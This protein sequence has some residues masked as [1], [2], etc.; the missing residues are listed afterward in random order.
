MSNFLR[1][2]RPTSRLSD[3]VAGVGPGLGIA[4]VIALAAY[5]LEDIERALFGKAWIE[6]LVLAIVLGAGVR[7]AGL[8]AGHAHRGIEIAAKPV[9]E[10]A[11]VLLGASLDVREILASGPILI[12]AIA[13]IVALAIGAGVAIGRAL[14]LPAKMALLVACGNAICGNSAIA[15]VAPVIDAEPDDVAA[16]IGFTAVLGVVVV[17][18]MPMLTGAF[19]L[20]GAAAGAF[21]GLTAYAVPQVLAAAAPLGPAAVQ[22][23]AL[24]KLTRVLMLGPVCAL[25]ALAGR[26]LGWE[27]AGRAR[28]SLHHLVPWFILGFLALAMSRSLGWLPDRLIA[29]AAALTT[30]LTVVAMAGLGLGVDVRHIRAAGPRVTAAVVLSLL[31]LG[32]LSMAALAI[33]GLA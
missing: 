3:A 33:A 12:A 18:A 5:T 15:A 10:V 7:S 2:V 19:G 23:G 4:I 24:V 17:L 16:A 29:D 8:V 26:R 20:A 32:A 30:P 14:G 11:I 9:L 25:L 22:M 28:P 31:G 1:A 21:A 27:G 6:A 13:A